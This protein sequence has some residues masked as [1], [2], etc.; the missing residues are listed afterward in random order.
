MMNLR[1]KYQ[2]QKLYEIQN[3]EYDPF[4]DCSRCD[5]YRKIIIMPNIMTQIFCCCFISKYIKIYDCSHCYG[6]GKIKK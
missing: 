3:T 1:K 6:T 5:G 2:L 4:R